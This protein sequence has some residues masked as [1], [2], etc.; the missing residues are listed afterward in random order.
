M[1]LVEQM[2]KGVEVENEDE[3][4]VEGANP[5]FFT[6]IEIQDDENGEP[7][8]RSLVI[9]RLLLTRRR[10][11]NDQRQEIFGHDVPPTRGF[12]TLSLI[13]AMWR[14]SLLRVWLPN[15]G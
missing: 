11:L 10:E 6:P 12:V 14:I 1:N 15:W 5:Y 3:V 2:E 7:L 9:Q 8:G 4:G 13:V